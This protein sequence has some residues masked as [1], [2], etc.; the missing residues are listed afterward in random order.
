MNK[1]TK[2][3]RWMLYLS[4]FISGLVIFTTIFYFVSAKNSTDSQTKGIVLSIVII[5]AVLAVL[6]MLASRIKLKKVQRIYHLNTSKHM[7]IFPTD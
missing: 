6:S 4:L 2:K 5:I 7:K 1:L 3:S